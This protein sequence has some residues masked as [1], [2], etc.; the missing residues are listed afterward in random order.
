MELY[1][2]RMRKCPII[3]PDQGGGGGGGVNKSFIKRGLKMDFL[4]SPY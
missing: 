4:R 2:T 1:A 3:S